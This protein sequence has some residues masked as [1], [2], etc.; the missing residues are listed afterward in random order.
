MTR[1]EKIEELHKIV[2][3]NFKIVNR[4]KAA[5]KAGFG[6]EETYVP[7]G[8]VGQVFSRGQ[9]EYFQLS[10]AWGGAKPCQYAIC[11]EL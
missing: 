3:E 9:K 8:G 7:S 4:K 10:Y 1:Q 5:E 2:A 11:V 6:W